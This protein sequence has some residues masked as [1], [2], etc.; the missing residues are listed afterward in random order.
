MPKDTPVKDS[1]AR[2]EA[3]GDDMVVTWF[4]QAIT[5]PPSVEDWDPDVLEAFETGKA[6]SALRS[7]LGDQYEAA[8][9]RF[10]KDQG[11]KA[12]VGD[13]TSLVDAIAQ[14]YGF[15]DSGE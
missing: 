9:R 11:R 14:S 12:T 8:R 2:L 3:I 7:L 5:L 13:L 6:I 15:T 10:L 1:P 4:G